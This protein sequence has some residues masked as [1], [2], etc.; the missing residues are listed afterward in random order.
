MTTKNSIIVSARLR[1]KE[2]I[3]LEIIKKENELS[4]AGVL[5]FA[6]AKLI[7]QK[8]GPRL[9]LP[10]H[11][12]Q[13]MFYT[14]LL[15]AVTNKENPK[16]SFGEVKTTAY[17]VGIMTSNTRKNYI[18]ALAAQGFCTKNSHYLVVLKKWDTHTEE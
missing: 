6:I 18:E 7:Q 17:K 9:I 11:R 1:R 5:R 13:R 4:T 10:H 16:L 12:K 2:Y 8:P 15:K 14:E 3:I